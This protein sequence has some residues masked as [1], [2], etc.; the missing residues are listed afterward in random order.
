MANT[1]QSTT[2]EGL[3]L[4]LGGAASG[5]SDFAERLVTG[6]ASRPVYIAT[7]P[8]SDPDMMSRIARHKARREGHNWHTIEA[9]LTLASALSEVPKGQAVLVDCATLW[10]SN[11]M[12]S[13]RNIEAET[14]ALLSAIQTCASPVVVV[15]NEV[16]LGGVPANAVARRFNDAQGALNRSLAEQAGSVIVVAAGLPLVLKGTLP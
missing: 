16:G 2:L 6:S 12:F 14:N 13:K 10:L 15:S 9:P 4:V 3:T 11:I 5:K 7:A 1:V 8:V